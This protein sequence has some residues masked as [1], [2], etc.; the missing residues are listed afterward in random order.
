[1]GT[2]LLETKLHIPPVRPE[3]VSRP[4]LVERL[5]AGLHRKL[6]L[7]SAPAGFGKSTLLSE[8][9]HALRDTCPPRAVAWLSLEESDNDV[10]RFLAYLI[11]ALQTV[12][13]DIGVPAV[14]ML[15]SH[16][17]PTVEA[18]LSTLINEI[19]VVA[20]GDNEDSP[21]V[22]VLDDYHRIT[23]RPV[24]ESLA[25]LLDHL[26][27][28]IHVAI[29]GRADPPLPLA[30]LRAR[31]QLTELRAADLR[32]TPNEAAAFLNDIMELGLSTE[33]ITA[34]DA[35]TEG[36][37]AGLQ[38]AALSMRG[39]RDVTGFI[40]AF[41]GSHRFVLDYLVEEVLDR[42]PRF[43]QDFLLRTSILERMIA[44]LCDAIPGIGAEEQWNKGD[45][46]EI[47]APKPLR[48]SAPLPPSP[49]APAQEILQYLEQANLFIVPLDDERRWYRYHHLFADLLRSRLELTRPD[50]VPA[51]H[52]RA[53]EWY[54]QSGLITEAVSHAFAAGDAV[55]LARLVEG[56]ALA[57]MDHGELTTLL[58]WFDALPEETIRSQPW[59]S[60]AYAWALIYAGRL[61]DLNPLLLNAE[62]VLMES[63]RQSGLDERA[64]GHISSI[65]AYML[66]L[67]GNM[68]HGAGL[69]RQALE[70]LPTQDSTARGWTAS[71][72]AN[73]LRW[74]GDLAGADRAFAEASAISRAAGAG[75]VAV[76]VL[77]DWA[78]LQM[79][80]GQLHKAAATCRDALSLA[81]HWAL[82]GGRPL[83]VAGY[84]HARLS[85]VLR[86]WNDLEAALYH[87]RE[88]IHL[89]EP[90]GWTEA[91][92]GSYISL[93][94]VLDALGHSD[95]ALDAAHK[96]RRVARGA[97]RWFEAYARALEARLWLA[98]GRA[99]AANR[100][101]SEESRSTTANRT[102]F[103]YAFVHLTLARIR[104]AQARAD[105]AL[106]TLARLL[107][108]A[109]AAGA[110][111]LRIEVL[112]LQAMAL[113]AQGKVDESLVQLERSLSLAE[114]EG[115]V[116]TF[117]DEG[118]RMGDL[119]R[120]AA[121]QGI[122]LE[123][124]SALLAA[125]ESAARTK[126]VQTALVEP[127]SERELEVLRVLATGL[128]NK[129]IAETLF[130]AVGTVKQHLKSI[131]GKLQVHS[132]TEAAHRARDLGIL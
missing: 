107:E 70:Q 5:N 119:L 36:W 103:E 114:P 131:Y 96:A 23:A 8:W 49:S 27:P 16:Q 20:P 10:R 57:M 69:A 45:D 32:F 19:G 31:G 115:Y 34:L 129:E 92:V 112:A 110:M 25:F 76:D 97:S 60:V 85:V 50:Q 15:Q 118:A 84:A 100:W 58:A 46:T 53:S 77:C 42:Q 132:R 33:D 28:Q 48:P 126:G 22:L 4:R 81:D 101:A 47:S 51:L 90:W 122:R 67:S 98:Q 65:R 24:H 106:D 125:L 128:S 95:D 117:I 123:Y 93:A 54:E 102:G 72:L 82:Q 88:G 7:V 43:I 120:R 116:R 52:H 13:P 63:S 66:V 30:R 74:S 35:R 40:K 130:I 111:G 73:A 55:R 62:E 87:A 80:R 105:Q 6:T 1:M 86:E 127:L 94:T 124:V 44:P 78:G 9:A 79:M 11:G 37:I 99:V 71:L 64:K 3:L 83:P 38:M 109:E 18:I 61:D 89:S 2:P 21:S 104:I 108:A 26:P 113:Q 68:E 91:L 17:P 41:S 29:A 12:R 121:A 59:L 14:A 75:H 39:R 56:N